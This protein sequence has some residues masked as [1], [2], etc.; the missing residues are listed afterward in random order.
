MNHDPLSVPYSRRSFARLVGGATFALAGAS[1]LLAETASTEAFI[2]DFG[3]CTRYQDFQMLRGFGYSYVEAKTGELLR[4]KEPEENL[5]EALA[6]V[7]E[8]EIRIHSCTSFLPGN[9]KATGPKAD[10]EAVLNYS[11]DI[12]RRAKMF[13]VKGLVF[14]SSASRKIPAGFEKSK[15]E[16]Q[17]IS[18][19]KKMAPLAESHG[20]EVWLEPL[21]RDE[22]NLVNT[23]V[24]GAAIVEKVGHPSLGMVCDIFHMA[25]N[26]EDPKDIG[27]CIEHIRHCHIA[28]KAKRTPPGVEKF[29]FVPYLAAL[30]AGGYSKTMSMECLWSDLAGQAQPAREYAVS[31]MKTI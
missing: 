15:G 17:L 9:L 1:K 28:E 8:G 31:Q 3:V 30:K 14:G 5:A 6:E 11:E 29:D 24:E 10:H 13:G 21:N 20:V 25:R 2:T 22:D 4:P 26:G 7:R 27:K 19:L 23:Q 16:E 18:L 12:F